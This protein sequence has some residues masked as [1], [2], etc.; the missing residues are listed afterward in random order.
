MTGR[1]IIV[2]GANSGVGYETAKFLSNGG[3]EVILACRNEE[4]GKAAVGKIL[5]SNPN[6]LASFMQVTNYLFLYIDFNSN[7]VP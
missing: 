4:K 2:T 1:V 5:E 7:V 6:A 3:N